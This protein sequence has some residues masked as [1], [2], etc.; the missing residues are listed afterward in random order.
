MS[1]IRD[2]ANLLAQL[3]KYILFRYVKKWVCIEHVPEWGQKIT[4][5]LKN[6]TYR[7]FFIVC[8]LYMH[9]VIVKIYIEL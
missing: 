7:Y 4:E 3:L 6:S 1:S 8:Y 9:L 2:S 5:E